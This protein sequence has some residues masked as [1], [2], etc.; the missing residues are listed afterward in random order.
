MDS[1]QYDSV[2]LLPSEQIGLH[3]QDGW[4]LSYI[5]KG[6]GTRLI[7]DTSEPFG[8][9]E[10]VLIPPGIPHCWYFDGKDVDNRGR[11]FNITVRFFDSFLKT[12]KN[13]FPEFE[14]TIDHIE[15]VTSAVKLSRV[16]TEKIIPLLERMREESPEKRLI[17]FL[18]ILS[19]IAS[20]GNDRIVGSHT[21]VNLI[22]KR[23]SDVRI[24]VI[25]NASREF[26]LEEVAS[27][28][29]MNKSAF[30][31]FFKKASGQTFVEYLNDYRVKMAC[32]LLCDGN[33]AVSD[34]CFQAGFNSVPYFNRVFKKATGLPPKEYR[35]RNSGQGV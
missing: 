30:C 12:C 29:G 17:S 6:S 34:A 3:S 21:P 26:S 31:T 27:H 16:K 23:L 20:K 14:G 35:R 22:Q 9:G 5:I 13:S 33:M 18:S 25:C 7:G 32:K 10:V 19:E 1:F 24:Y 15:S 2:H 28:I 4:E 8:E 11:I